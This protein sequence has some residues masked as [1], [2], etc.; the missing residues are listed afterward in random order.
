MRKK[1][2][3]FQKVISKQEPN[4]IKNDVLLD[5]EEKL[6]DNSKLTDVESDDFI[7]KIVDESLESVTQRREREAREDERRKADMVKTDYQKQ[8]KSFEIKSK[9]AVN[10][11][12]D[13]TERIKKEFE[14]YKKSSAEKETQAKKTG[15]DEERERII[16]IEVEEKTK[17]RFH[18]YVYITI[19][20]LIIEIVAF[21]LVWIYGQKNPKNDN[22]LIK[23]IITNAIWIIATIS[24]VLDVVVIK[25]CFREFDRDK[26]EQ[27]V[28]KEVARKYKTS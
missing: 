22:L 3:I 17:Q 15:A 7:D 9:A 20:M 21:A 1:L 11:Q 5:I 8:L 24:A 27:D 6:K 12:H 4:D 26:I 25:G 13:E 23:F 18:R 28:R 10:A 19:A 16:D 14:D 2:L